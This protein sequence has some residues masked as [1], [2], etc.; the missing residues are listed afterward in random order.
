M[1]AGRKPC[2]YGLGLEEI[3]IDLDEKGFIK[4]N[5]HFQT[6]I[7]SIYTI[8]DAIG[9]ALL[10]HKAEEEGIAVVESLSSLGKNF[11]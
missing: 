8:G 1:S 5:D 3:N 10:S 9:G 7:L 2:I 6:N 11:Y 4:A